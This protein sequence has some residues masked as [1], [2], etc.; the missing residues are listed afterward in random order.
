MTDILVSSFLLSLVLLG[1]HSYFGLEIIRRGIIFTDLAIGQMA[2]LGA[3]VAILFFDGH[4]IYPISLVFALGAAFLSALA[5][6]REKNLEAFIGLLYAFSASGV[7][8]LLSKSPHGME[9]FNNLLAADILLIPLTKII[10]VAV[11][12]LFLGIFIVFIDKK[13]RGFVKDLLFFTTFAFTV[14]SS[15]QLAGVFVVFALLVGPAFIATKFKKGK[16]LIISWIVGLIINLIAITV[17]YRFDFPTGY[18]IVLLH[19]FSAIMFS[20]LKKAPTKKESDNPLK[21]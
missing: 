3:A 14:T 4:H 15:V 2:A 11:L 19:S 18:T 13:T 20:L 16:P 21:N 12:Y 7:F 9:E 5:A 10:Y 17:S 1:I 8:I 6:H